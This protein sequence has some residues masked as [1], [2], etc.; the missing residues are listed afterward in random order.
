MQKLRKSA[1]SQSTFHSN[2]KILPFRPV[3]IE[4]L[5]GWV[6]VEGRSWSLR[7]QAHLASIRKLF[8]VRWEGLV[9]CRGMFWVIWR[10]AEVLVSRFWDVKLWR[11]SIRLDMMLRVERWEVR[12][13]RSDFWMVPVLR[14]SKTWGLVSL[15]M[16]N[17]SWLRW[18]WVS[19]S[20]RGGCVGLRLFRSL[21][22]KFDKFRN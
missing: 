11:L 12:S 7:G 22:S 9:D 3:A 6:R 16:K 10:R 13:P 1:N 19:V 14:K 4:G 2:Q 17:M 15:V 5:W 8:F 20:G 18:S 21:F